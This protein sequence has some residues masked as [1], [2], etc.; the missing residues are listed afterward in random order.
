MGT[1]N[2][3]QSNVSHAAQIKMAK[4][5]QAL[6]ILTGIARCSWAMPFLSRHDLHQHATKFSSTTFRYRVWEYTNGTLWR[7]TD[8]Y[9]S[10]TAGKQL[11]KINQRNDVGQ[12]SSVYKFYSEFVSVE[13]GEH[14]KRSLTVF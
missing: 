8:T 3:Q 2:E 14:L 9:Y 13:R 12:W 6:L 5:I 11:M 4:I 1:F 7:T 10:D